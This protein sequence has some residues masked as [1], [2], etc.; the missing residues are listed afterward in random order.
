MAKQSRGSHSDNGCDLFDVVD[1]AGL[2]VQLG[3]QA[4]EYLLENLTASFHP[5]LGYLESM[6]G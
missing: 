6:H 1:C 3:T 4:K 2:T 5:F